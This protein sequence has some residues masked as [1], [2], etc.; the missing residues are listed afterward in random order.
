MP[1][2]TVYNDKGS[3]F[4]SLTWILAAWFQPVAHQVDLSFMQRL[5][6]RLLPGLRTKPWYG[7]NLAEHI[8]LVPSH[9][10]YVGM[11]LSL[12]ITSS[13]FGKILG[14]SKVSL[15]SVSWVYLCV[16]QIPKTPQ[17]AP[18]ICLRCPSS[19]CYLLGSGP[20][21][22]QRTHV[23]KSNWEPTSEQASKILCFKMIFLPFCFY[24]WMAEWLVRT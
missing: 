3:R 2:N 18:L 23:N 15:S 17:V 1:I 9:R 11:K 7:K 13:S 5:L 10:C 19:S 8:S 6:K 21:I 4:I 24:Q 16:S 14:C 20:A 12:D 22:L